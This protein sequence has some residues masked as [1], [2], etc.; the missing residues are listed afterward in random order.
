VAGTGSH[1]PYLFNAENVARYAPPAWHSA[2]TVIDTDYETLDRLARSPRAAAAG[3]E[4]VDPAVEPALRT[5]PEGLG[6]SAPDAATV[7][8]R[9]VRLVHAWDLGDI[10]PRAPGEWRVGVALSEFH[11][12]WPW[13]A[14]RWQFASAGLHSNCDVMWWGSAAE[15]QAACKAAASLRCAADPHIE[16]WLPG[17]EKLTRPGLLPAQPRLHS[18]FSKFWTQATRGFT[19]ASELLRVN[20]SNSDCGNNAGRD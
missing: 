20:S 7:R 3:A 9:P 5:A 10:F 16:A 14:A 15:V 2:G 1:K 18:S 4:P 8:G 11:G 19:D 6:F 17:P 13:S 12:R